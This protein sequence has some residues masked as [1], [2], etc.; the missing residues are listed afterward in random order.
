MTSVIFGINGQDGHYLKAIL[1]SNNHQVIG[2]SRSDGDWIKGNVSDF[3]FVSDIIK[4]HKPHFVFHLAAN[5]TTHHNALFEN[6]ETIS[7]GTLN[8]LESVRLQSPKSKVFLSG[9]AV[10]FKNEGLP[11]SELSSFEPNSPYAVSRIQSVYAGRYYRTLGLKV[12]VGYF[13]HHDSPLRS[14]RH[15]NMKII[16]TAL[17]IKNGTEDVLEIGNPEIIKEFNHADDIMQ[18]VWCLVKQDKIFEATI[19]SGIG[20]SINDWIN[21]CF[22]KIGISK[23]DHI[24]LNPKYTADFL[25]LVSNP[26]TIKSLGWVPN[27]DIH[28]LA[29]DMINNG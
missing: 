7:T 3:E 5:S 9:S 18:A 20:Y 10:Q 11:V 15:L 16:K 28:F 23:N 25:S 21:I 2:V 6:H 1:L 13:F 19:G 4:L 26:Q 17:N 14:K 29:N 27:Y 22:E 24:R 8:I 12:Y